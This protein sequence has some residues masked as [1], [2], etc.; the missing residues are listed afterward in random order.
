MNLQ[1]MSK[2]EAKFYGVAQ[3]RKGFYIKATVTK[4]NY[5]P[6]QSEEV[7]LERGNNGV[8]TKALM[9]GNKDEEN[10]KKKNR[11]IEIIHREAKAGK[12]YSKSRFKTQYAGKDNEIGVGEKRLVELLEELVAE[13]RLILQTPEK[14]QRNTVFIL[15]VPPS[16]EEVAEEYKRASRGE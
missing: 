15:A 9:R 6:P 11:I 12:E 16:I 13:D 2:D 5:A 4:N 1:A 14:T 7:W 3:N 8:L 10:E